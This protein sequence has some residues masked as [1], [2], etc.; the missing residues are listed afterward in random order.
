MH[1]ERDWVALPMCPLGLK[2]EVG[3]AAWKGSWLGAVDRKPE[4]AALTTTCEHPRHTSSAHTLSS[5]D[6]SKSTQ[7]GRV[8]PSPPV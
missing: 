4:A 3:Q 6:R 8:Q 1:G 7:S 5:S 2:E